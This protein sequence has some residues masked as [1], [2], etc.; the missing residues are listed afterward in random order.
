METTSKIVLDIWNDPTLVLPK[1]I[2]QWTRFTLDHIE[3]IRDIGSRSGTRQNCVYL[4]N[5]NIYDNVWIPAVLKFMQTFFNAKESIYAMDEMLL[6]LRMARNDGVNFFLSES[7]FSSKSFAASDEKNCNQGLITSLGYYYE[8][9]KYRVGIF[10]P[11]YDGSIDKIPLDE[12]TSD[13]RRQIFLQ[14]TCGLKNLHS[15]GFRHNDVKLENVLFKKVNGKYE[16]VLADFGLSD[17]GRPSLLTV[18]TLPYRPFEMYGDDST[19][20]YSYKTDIF[21]LMTM[22]KALTRKCYKHNCYVL[23]Y[24]SG[25]FHDKRD[26]AM[27]FFKNVENLS[28]VGSYRK[29]T[30]HASLFQSTLSDSKDD[31][32]IILEKDEWMPVEI[33][34]ACLAMYFQHRPSIYQLARFFGIQET[35]KYCK[36][37]KSAVTSLHKFLIDELRRRYYLFNQS[38]G[39]YDQATFENPTNRFIMNILVCETNLDLDFLNVFCFLLRTIKW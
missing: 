26:R 10:L 39:A 34:K 11:V 30:T 31:D 7:S 8:Q 29:S 19:T 24:Q 23:Q 4:V 14:V 22:Y 12:M 36:S 33:Q 15:R 18:Q 25:V 2:K 37:A 35:R 27:Q 6:H 28:V 3:P 17:S 38:P 32:K 13:L 1:P 16:F 21:A 5:L 9:K 20:F